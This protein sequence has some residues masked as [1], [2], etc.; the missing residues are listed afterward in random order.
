MRANAMTGARPPLCYTHS[1]PSLCV[2]KASKV[3]HTVRLALSQEI[4]GSYS[5]LSRL[6]KFHTKGR[7]LHVPTDGKFKTL[8]NQHPPPDNDITRGFSDGASESPSVRDSYSELS[9]TPSGERVKTVQK[10][11]VLQNITFSKGRLLGKLWGVCQTTRNGF[12]FIYA[13]QSSASRKKRPHENSGTS[14]FVLLCTS[15]ASFVLSSAPPWW[16]YLKENIGVSIQNIEFWGL[17]GASAVW[18]L[19]MATQKNHKW[20]V[21]QMSGTRIQ[22]NPPKKP[23]K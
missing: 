9:T 14:R 4:K 21:P 10:K 6:S 11:K 19:M 2:Q 22:K 13:L 20:P 3:N 1:L 12:I 7:K 15:V 8:T 5:S 17:E 18:W 16:K 23:H